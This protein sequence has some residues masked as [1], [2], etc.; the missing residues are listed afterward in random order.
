MS[1]IIKKVLNSSVVLVE[2]DLG[3]EFIMLG[4]G[5]GYGKKNGSMVDDQDV[6]QVFVPIEYNMMKKYQ[7]LMDS[8]PIDVLKITQEIILDAEKMLGYD[9][10]KNLYFILADHLNFAIERV[11]L[12]IIITNRVF[13]EIKTYYPKEFKVGIKAIEMFKERLDVNLPQEEAANIAFHIANSSS[14]NNREYDIL[15]YAKVIGEIN[16]IVVFSLNK[17]IDKDSVHYIRFITHIKF[18]VERYFSKK[19]LSGEDDLLLRQMKKDY[20]KEIIIAEKVKAFLEKKY[21]YLLT[22]EELTFLTVHI[23]RLNRHD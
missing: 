21:K 7:E 23:T 9:F 18:F 8:I 12:G 19:M 3:K 11:K 13:W 22:Q 1:Y 5:I 2:N 15:K 16:N 10:N 14:T 20:K 6:N 17:P 4:R